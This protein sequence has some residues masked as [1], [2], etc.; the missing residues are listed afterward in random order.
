MFDCIVT[1]FKIYCIDVLHSIDIP[2]NVDTVPRYMTMATDVLSTIR[3]LSIQLA[4]KPLHVLNSVNSKP[5]K[6]D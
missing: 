1:P 6:S 4:Y 3:V 2:I 5:L